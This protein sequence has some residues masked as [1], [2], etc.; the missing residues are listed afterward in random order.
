MSLSDTLELAIE[1]I[2]R[3]SVTPHDEGCQA[4]IAHRLAQNGFT[5]ESLPFGVGKNRVENLFATH[6]SN[7]QDRT[8]EPVLCFIGHTD[9]V[10]AGDL[11]QWDSHPFEPTIKNGYLYGRGAADMKGSV[12]SMVVAAEHFVHHMPHHKGTVA[13]LLTSDEEGPSIYGIR[14]VVEHFKKINQKITWA[15]V[16]EPSSQ[17]TLGDTLKN[18]R[19]GS[20]GGTLTIHGKQ[21]HIAYP[22][23]ANNPISLALPAL[24][25]LIHHVWD[26]GTPLFPPTQF[27]ISNIQSGT[28]ATN[29]IPG[30]L[31]LSFNLRFSPQL[32]P[33]AIQETLETILSHHGLQYTLHWQLSG[34][35]FFTEEHKPLIQATIAV[36]KEQGIAPELSTA[37]GTSDGRFVVTL[38][39]EVVELGPVNQTI[40]QVNECVKIADLD[41]L[42]LI[43]QKLLEK[44]LT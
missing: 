9:V 31:T 14:A 37:G 44:L 4:L 19:R 32:T 35:P 5:I 30:T 17:S 43:Y 12:A 24:N 26:E 27:Q 1:L 28:G 6:R 41:K 2:K 15:V 18:G 3:P 33:E 42:T 22:Q 10:P 8:D 39:A 20:L 21:G 40:H 25:E 23:L 11:A 38:G 34:L 16:G 13:L 36:L 7:S 29:V